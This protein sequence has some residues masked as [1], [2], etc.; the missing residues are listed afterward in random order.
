MID[1]QAPPNWRL[2]LAGARQVGKSSICAPADCVGRAG[3]GAPAAVRA[4][5]SSAVR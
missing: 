4:R 3:A 5:S 2:E 1:V